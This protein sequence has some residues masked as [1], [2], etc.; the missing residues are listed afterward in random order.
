MPAPATT[1]PDFD[2]APEY[3]TLSTNV[4]GFAAMADVAVHRCIAAGRGRIVG[5]S[6][7]A[8]FRGS[9]NAVGYAASKAF[10][11]VYL[12]G[13]RDLLRHRAKGVTVTEAC[14]G[15]VDTPLM[16]FPN[17]FWVSTAE[18]AARQIVDGALA[19][20]KV[21]YITR[22]WRLIAWLLSVLPR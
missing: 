5:V 12:D 15:F 14:P 18:K 6:S 3:A 16:K 7:V 20:R 4:I 22:R 17:A 8:R 13:V 10:V 9:R 2:W 11:S 19:G 21:V 1:T